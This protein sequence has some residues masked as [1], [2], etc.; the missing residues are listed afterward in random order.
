MVVLH[1]NGRQW[2]KVAGGLFGFG[3]HLAGAGRR[4]H[5]RPE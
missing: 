4:L 2:S 3:V 1:W 5:A